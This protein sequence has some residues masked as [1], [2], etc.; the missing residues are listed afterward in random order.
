VASFFSGAFNRRVDCRIGGMLELGTR[1]PVVL[2]LVGAA[3]MGALVGIFLFLRKDPPPS[4][5]PRS[6]DD[7]L[8]AMDLTGR[9]LGHCF[10]ALMVLSPLVALMRGDALPI[11]V[12]PLLQFLIS[13]L[14]APGVT[15]IH[16]AGLRWR[17][18]N[19]TPGR[20][21]LAGVLTVLLTWGAFIVFSE[22]R[23]PKLLLGLLGSSF[24]VLAMAASVPLCASTL[25]LVLAWL[26][27]PRQN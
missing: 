24:G 5:D 22:L 18:K 15:A 23:A 1:D 13:L 25:S 7:L 11:L 20:T 26:S 21:W 17:K 19:W 16:Y 12:L 8:R 27:I 10:L 3:T 4:D 2:V 9:Y 6:F 14:I